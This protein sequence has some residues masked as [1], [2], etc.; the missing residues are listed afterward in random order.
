MGQSMLSQ[1]TG[2]TGA[3]DKGVTITGARIALGLLLFAVVWL[4]VLNGTTR[5]A[6]ADNIEQLN[7]VRSIQWGYYKHPPLPTWL[8]GALVWAFDPSAA[9]TYLLG[10]ACTLTSMALLWR[11]LSLVRGSHYATIALLAA[12]CIT[13]YNARLQ[14]YNHNVVL[15]LATTCAALLAHAAMTR[16]GIRWWIGLGLALGLGTLAKYQMTVTGLCLLTFWI[17]QRGWKSREKR[18]GL[19]V[20][21]LVALLVVA[22]HLYWLTTHDYQP[23]RYAMSSSLGEDL[24]ASARLSTSAVWLADQLFNRA[25]PAWLL[26]LIAAAPWRRS[27]RSGDPTRAGL[28]DGT[29]ALLICW[30]AV[31]LAFV[32]LLGITTGAELQP[33]W[34][35][36]FLLFS[37]PAV[38]EL[39]GWSEHSARKQTRRALIAFAGLQTL[40]VLVNFLTSPLGPPRWRSKHQWESFDA[41]TLA[42]QLAPRARV[43]LG[44]PIRVVVGERALA[45]ALS[46]GI[47]EHPLV[48][49]DGNYAFSPWVSPDV[50]ARCGALR[51]G[52]KSEL[53][54]GNP[55]GVDFPNLAWAIIARRVQTKPC[56]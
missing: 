46:L 9:L 12:L 44:G 31:P 36:A 37:V 22:P 54:Q 25:L 19:G 7:W 23:I 41:A 38:M 13:Y 35:T 29:A 10:A 6:P 2:A 50:V 33:Q 47:S 1:A 55:V 53:P 16:T 43:A 30:G 14:F 5:V 52:P 15:M 39:L 45:G 4:L 17:S 56:A 34:G 49:I 20:S 8:L 48:L 40:L 21:L 18:I 26:L 42:Q 3:T 11:F 32:V 28:Q 27:G 24:G 51:I